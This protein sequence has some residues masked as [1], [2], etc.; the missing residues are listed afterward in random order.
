MFSPVIDPAADEGVTAVPAILSLSLS[1]AQFFLWDRSRSVKY[2]RFS[3]LAFFFLWEIVN[4]THGIWIYK[5]PSG[6]RCIYNENMRRVKNGTKI[7]IILFK[8]WKHALKY[9]H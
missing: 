8:N 3:I 2:S 5:I 7:R 9:M 4:E 6:G 1:Q